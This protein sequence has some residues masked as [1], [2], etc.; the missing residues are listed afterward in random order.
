MVMSGTLRYALVVSYVLIGSRE[1]YLMTFPIV[2]PT[3][4]TKVI[5]FSVYAIA[6]R[7]IAGKLL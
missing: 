7:A 4:R 1:Y 2:F 3:L 6:S 5:Y